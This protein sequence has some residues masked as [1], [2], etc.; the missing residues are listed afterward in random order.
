VYSRFSTTL[1]RRMWPNTD[2]VWAAAFVVSGAFAL[3]TA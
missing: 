2:G 1:L 3:L